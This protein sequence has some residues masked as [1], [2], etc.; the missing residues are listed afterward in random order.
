LKLKKSTNEIAVTINKCNSDFNGVP[1]IDTAQYLGQTP[2]D[3]LSKSTDKHIVSNFLQVC[4]ITL[5]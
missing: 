3:N 2:K 1:A 4:K 5:K